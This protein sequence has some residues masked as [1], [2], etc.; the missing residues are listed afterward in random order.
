MNGMI[1]EKKVKIKGMI[2]LPWR[3]R[4]IGAAI[5]A[6]LLIV[7][8]IVLSAVFSRPGGQ[9]TVSEASLKEIIK[10]GNLSTV[11]YI[12]N[13]ILEVKND[14]AE[15]DDTLYYVSYEG[16]VKAG[17]DFNELRFET[18]KTDKKYV[19]IIPEIKVNNADVKYE[20]MDFIFV[21]SKDNKEGVV[22]EAYEKC[23]ADLLAKAEENPAVKSM[24]RESAEDTIEAML[25]PFE[26]TLKNGYEFEIRFAEEQ[27]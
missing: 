18:D 26:K 1:E 20:S 11:E 5:V 16:V 24:A 15:K 19:V 6:V 25:T 7:T 4:L 9:T 21:N 12:Y 2:R 10:T 13:S 14:D 27:K 23:K 17:F 8:A 22:N 3:I